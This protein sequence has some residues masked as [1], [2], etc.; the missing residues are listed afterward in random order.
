M[1][2]QKKELTFEEKVK[3]ECTRQ[4]IRALLFVTLGIIIGVGWTFNFYEGRKLYTEIVQANGNGR[5]VIVNN[6]IASTGLNDVDSSEGSSVPLKAIF[7]AYTS[8]AAQTD[9]SPYITADGTNLKKEFGCVV[10]HNSLP[11]GTKVEIEGI[12]TCEVHD[13]GAARHGE[14]WFD[15]Y[16]G[17]DD[18]RAI[19]FGK[20]EL[21]YKIL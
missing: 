11:F 16:M 1:R 9:S 15:V 3:K 6:A 10:A 19:E 7:T 2:K 13:R 8:K 20:K 14:S 5:L 18:Q 17:N 21:E 12:G 4:K